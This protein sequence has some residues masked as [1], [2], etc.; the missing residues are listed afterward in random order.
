M[1]SEKMISI[2]E[3]L[4]IDNIMEKFKRHRYIMFI[5][6]IYIHIYMYIYEK[7]VGSDRMDGETIEREKIYIPF[8]YKCSI[9]DIEYS[10]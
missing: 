5:F 7:L 10:L 6:N 9:I 8:M 4:S 2:S 1:T 3:A